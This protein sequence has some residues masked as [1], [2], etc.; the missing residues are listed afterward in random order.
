MNEGRA[1]QGSPFFGSQ[2]G[3]QILLDGWQNPQ[4]QS[5]EDL[6]IH[7]DYCNLRKSDSVFPNQR[8]SGDWN[9]EKG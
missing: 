1:L 8:V 5:A 9:V 7:P 3:T 4:S 6:E 2:T